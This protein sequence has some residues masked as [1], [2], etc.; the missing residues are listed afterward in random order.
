[1][2]SYGPPITTEQARKAVSAALAEARA[3]NWTMA[4]AVVDPAGIL[5]YFERIDDTQNASSKIAI[6]K[7]RSA[8]LFKRPTKTFQD[9]VE[10]GGIGLRVMTLRGAM[11]VEGGVPLVVDGQIVGGLGRIRRHGG[12]GRPVRQ[13]RHRRHVTS[14]RESTRRVFWAAVWLAIVLV[15]IKAYYLGIPAG[16]RAHRRRK[17]LL[18]RSPPSPTAT[19]C[20][21]PSAG[22]ARGDP[23]DCRSR[24]ANGV[25]DLD[26]VRR[27]R[28]LRGG[29]RDCERH[30]LRNLRRLSHLSAARA[31][32]QP[33]N[34][35]LVGR[36]ERDTRASSWRWSGCRSLRRAGRTVRAVRAAR[37]AGDSATS[38]SRSFRSVGLADSRACTASPPAW[39][40]RQDRRIAENPHWVLISS[41]W[42][43]VTGDGTVRLTDQ[44]PAADLADFDPIGL[45][46]ASRLHCP[47]GRPARAGGPRHRVRRT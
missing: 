44:F 33:A 1:M 14:H 8:A 40:T 23:R 31:R 13:S 17:L 34:A 9:S 28:R 2:P 30:L 46:P 41:W 11:P 4:V 12:T 18:D 32:R 45:R 7:A 24:Q 26:A 21:P 39:T 15:A 38:G 19:S 29:L 37:A 22:Q 20:S 36:R 25:G 16:A 10:R 47:A 6:D 42:Q 27:V 5:V 35:E 43:V 3:N